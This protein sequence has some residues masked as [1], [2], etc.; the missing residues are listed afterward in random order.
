MSKF[1]VGSVLA[2]LKLRP[3]GAIQMCILL[4]LLLVPLPATEQRKIIDY[5]IWAKCLEWMGDLFEWVGFR[6]SSLH[7]KFA[8][9]MHV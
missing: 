4:L 6:P 1:T 2:P 7:V 9:Y 8:L 5:P 3:Y